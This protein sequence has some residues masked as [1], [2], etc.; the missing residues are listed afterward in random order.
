MIRADRGLSP[1]LVMGLANSAQYPLGP[2]ISIE[3]RS[4]SSGSTGRTGFGCLNSG[5]ALPW[6][7]E[8]T[9]FIVVRVVP[10]ATN[11]SSAGAMISASVLPGSYASSTFQNP[12]SL[13]SKLDC[14]IGS[15]SSLFTARTRSNAWS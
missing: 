8:S 13:R 1:D 15:S 4:R 7:P 5:P 6:G 3:Y 9:M 10:L 12:A 11:N 14:T 2:A